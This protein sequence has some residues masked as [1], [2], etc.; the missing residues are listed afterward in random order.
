[1][2]NA[3]KH[4]RFTMRGKKRLHRGPGTEHIRACNDRSVGR[5]GTGAVRI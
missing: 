3:V 2:T 5:D 4:F 1:V